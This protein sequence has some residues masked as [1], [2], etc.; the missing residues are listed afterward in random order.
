MQCE[1]S[2][3]HRAPRRSSSSG[4]AGTVAAA[5]GGRAER[6]RRA[7]SGGDLRIAQSDDQR[8]PGARP[9]RIRNRD[10]PDIGA[11]LFSPHRQPVMAGFAGTEPQEGRFGGFGDAARVM[12]ELPA[13]RESA[14]F[15]IGIGD[16]GGDL[17][18]PVGSVPRRQVEYV[19]GGVAGEGQQAVVFLLRTEAVPFRLELVEL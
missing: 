16:G 7:V 6:L 13:H 4:H 19:V 12:A 8:L 14:R 15:G 11:G 2:L 10:H 1:M 3:A 5:G 18:Q 17:R 9:G